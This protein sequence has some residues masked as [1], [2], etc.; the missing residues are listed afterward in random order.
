MGMKWTGMRDLREWLL[1]LLGLLPAGAAVGLLPRGNTA[2]LSILFSIHASYPH[3]SHVSIIF[4]RFAHVF[5]S[6]FNSH[7]AWKVTYS[8]SMLKVVQE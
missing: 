6:L 5:G 1:G 2:I 7:V 8:P 3:P 4:T